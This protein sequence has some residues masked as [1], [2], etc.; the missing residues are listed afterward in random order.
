MT[1]RSVLVL[2]VLVPTTL[3]SCGGKHDAGTASTAASPNEVLLTK[4]QLAQM[5]VVVEKVDLQDVDDTVLASGKVA[6]DDQKVL[7][8]F[9]PVT[10]KAIKVIAQ[11]GEHVNKGD[12]LL[13][14]ES[15]DIGQ[16]TS[17]VG[18]AMA[19]L[20]AAETNY[21][22]MKELLALKAVAQLDY[23]TAVNAYGQAKA[24]LERAQQKSALFH[25]GD[26]VGQTYTL[27]S[28][29]AGEVFY[30]NVATG[31][32]V[33]GQ[34][35]GT[36]PVEIFTIGDADQVWV[37]T[38]VFEVDIPRVKLGAKVVVNVPSWPG[39]DFVGKVDWISSALDPTTHATKVRCTF[40]NADRALKPEMFA[41][42]KISVDVKKAIAIPRSSVVRLGEQLV[43]FLDRGVTTDGHEKF[44]RLPVIVDEGEGG[45]W[46]TVDHGL[47]VGNRIVTGGALLMSGML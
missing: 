4:D 34:Y 27:R 13:M 30:K 16:V 14:I 41:T 7:H 5:K 15:P 24:E 38:D 29:I 25:S 11:L 44:E 47:D 37:L 21:Q 22:R 23:E 36:S 6:F 42:V 8:V 3:G 43:V 2:V 20:K 35:T 10:G 1:V 32:E 46:L 17:D 26:V 19:N 33:A 40:D 39:R 45:K 9:S 12:P 31:M 18:K 28:E